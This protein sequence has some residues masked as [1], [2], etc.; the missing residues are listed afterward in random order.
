M[1]NQEKSKVGLIPLI[2]L[3][4]GSIIGSGAFSFPGDMAKGASAG[5]I[6]IAWVITGI[7]MLTLGFVFQ[8][9]S[10][11]RSDLNCG[12]YS[13]AKEG[14]GDYT[15]FNCAWGH[16][17]SSTLGNVS[18]LVMLFCTLGYFIPAFGSGN[19]LIS[20]IGASI[21][22]WVIHALILKGVKTAALVNVITTIGKVIPIFIF[23]I[24]AIIMFKVNIFTL[25]FWGNMNTNLGSVMKQVRS[26]MLITLWAFIGIET[27]VI[28]SARAKIRKEVGKATIIGLLGVL[29]IYVLISLLALGTMRQAQL[30]GLKSPSMAYAL[31]FMIGKWGAIIVNLGLII[32]LLGAYLGWTLI[33][34]EVSYSGSI[35][36]AFPKLFSK[37]NAN[38]S[39][40]NALFITNLLI[41]FFLIC[42]FLSKS[43]YQVLYS[44]ASSAV[45]VPYFFSALYSLKLTI[46]KETYTTE[47]NNTRLRDMFISGLSVIYAIWLIYAAGMNYMLLLTIL[48]SAGIM[49][50]YK[51]KKEQNAIA[52]TKVEKTVAAIILILGV[53]TIYMMVTGNIK[54]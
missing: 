54:V 19:N 8:N 39:P 52:F 24:V 50:F 48:F 46:T 17:I 20:V 26:T 10:N 9:L 6:I 47:K 42:A 44:I 21:L 53:I 37:E 32:S 38:G 35:G 22:I 14:F 40:V 15:G 49:V 18:Y 11:R 45:L 31:E 5:A 1:E 27:A 25:D 23:V 12:I 13:Y 30:A 41:Q 43:T 29:I 51:A 36:N 4:I 34:A 16:W 28:L 7:G 33:C 3:V 2:G